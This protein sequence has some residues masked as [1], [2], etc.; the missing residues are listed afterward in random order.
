MFKCLAEQFGTAHNFTPVRQR[1]GYAD[2]KKIELGSADGL[3][4]AGFCKRL[5]LKG[6]QSIFQYLDVILDGVG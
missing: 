3:S 2:I 6:H 5:E 4:F 1:I